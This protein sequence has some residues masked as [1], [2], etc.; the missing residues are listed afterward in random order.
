[1]KPQRSLPGI[2]L[3]LG[4]LLA[5]LAGASPGLSQEPKVEF[6]ITEGTALVHIPGVALG[7]IDDIVWG[8]RSIVDRLHAEQLIEDTSGGAVFGLP[9][10]FRFEGPGVVEIHL[11][12]GDTLVRGIPDDTVLRL[13]TAQGD[14]TKA[15]CNTNLFYN[16]LSCGGTTTTYTSPYGCCD[17]DGNGN[18]SG[19]NDGN[20]VWLAWVK[21]RE[22]GWLVPSTWGNATNWCDRASATPGWSVSSTAQKNTIACNK[23]L[24]HVAWVTGLS[25]TSFTV[26]EQNCAVEPSCFA[27]GTRSKTRTFSSDWKF[28]KCTDT[29]KCGASVSTAQP[30]IS[31]VSPNPVTGSASPQAFTINGSGFE[32]GA[33]VT[34]RDTTANQT[35]ANRPASSFSSTKIVLN[36]N[37]STAAHNWSV[38]VINPNGKTSGQY[39][40]TVRSPVSPSPSISSVSPNPVTGSNSP[41]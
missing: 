19:A 15:T 3:I 4:I 1:M 25:S 5:A 29:T 39:L 12:N 28:I 16:R 34:L 7:E 10:D 6:E 18:A 24:G 9:A 35:Y 8:G 32:T 11:R 37:F 33:N 14:V 31:S 20:C 21:A 22:Y 38:E 13:R 26:T 36:S 41:Q 23:T 40:F 27:S 2:A 30:A 17:N